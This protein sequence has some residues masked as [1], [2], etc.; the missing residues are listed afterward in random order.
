MD[1]LA[2]TNNTLR[3]KR[4]A[5]WGGCGGRGTPGGIIAK[6]GGGGWQRRASTKPRGNVLGGWEGRD[7]ASCAEWGGNARTCGGGDGGIVGM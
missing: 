1:N 2:R 3:R 6:G 4:R 7:H 5:E